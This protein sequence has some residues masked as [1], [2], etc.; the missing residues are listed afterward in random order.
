MPCCVMVAPQILVLFVWV[1]V[2]AG[3]QKVAVLLMVAFYVFADLLFCM[4]EDVSAFVQFSLPL[5]FQNF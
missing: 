1:R 5:H 2:L 4:G 3:Q